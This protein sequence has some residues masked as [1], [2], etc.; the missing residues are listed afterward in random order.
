[1][2]QFAWGHELAGSVHA[3]H[4]YPVHCVAYTGTHDNNTSRGWLSAV[5]DKIIKKQIGDYTGVPP[6]RKNVH[7]WM[8]RMVWAS[9]AQTV[10]VPMQDILGLDESARM[11]EPSVPHG[12]WS[13]R[14][15]SLP[16]S[17]KL[18]KA[19]RSLLWTF[20]RSEA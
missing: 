17:N 14:L 4:N 16:D 5:D 13:W 10:I 20:G 2:L 18:I 3:P 6:K 12:N 8:T 1:V 7:E 11:N 19:L 9:V 15:K